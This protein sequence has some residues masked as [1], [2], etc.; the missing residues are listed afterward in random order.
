[1]NDPSRVKPS[2]DRRLTPDRAVERDA[3][4]I[5][6]LSLALGAA[7]ALG[8][9]AFAGLGGGAG[10]DRVSA[11]ASGA[12]VTGHA[13]ASGFYP[14]RRQP[15]WVRV[16]NPF[17]QRVRVRSIRTWVRDPGTGC[18]GDNLVPRRSRGLRQLRRGNWRH[19]RIPPHR[20]RRVRVRTRLRAKAPDPC[21]GTTFPLRFRIK[22]KVWGR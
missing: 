18:A 10:A 6:T 7:L 13:E 12:E 2:L 19:V 5:K 16:R 8:A 15:V 1:L 17:D 20:S 3:M 22:V 21:Q 14:G 11:P 9:L 4:K